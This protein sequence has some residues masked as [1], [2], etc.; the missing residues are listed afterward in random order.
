[1]NNNISD[2]EQLK[3]VLN[4]YMNYANQGDFDSWI[5][6]WTENGVQMASDDSSKIGINEIKKRMKPLFE[7]MI[8]DLKLLAIEDVRVY[9]D[10]GLTR[11]SYTLSVTPKKGGN[12]MTIVPNGKAL[13]LY[14]RQSDKTW[15]I[16]YDCVNSN[17]PIN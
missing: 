12:K 17:V 5:S 15:K 6:L 3:D 16:I 9:G 11:C 2:I 1:M 13:T 8:N 4:L 7:E 14:E 10:L